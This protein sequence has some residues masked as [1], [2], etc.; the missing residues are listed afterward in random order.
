MDRG[1]ITGD[2]T[3]RERFG[4]Y[5][6]LVPLLAFVAGLILVPVIGT[7]LDSLHQDAS[8]LPRLFV[9]TGNFV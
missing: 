5:L 6:F 8:F 1:S 9:G 3:A 4:E 7:F 2:R